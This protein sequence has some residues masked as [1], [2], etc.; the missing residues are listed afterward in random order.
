MDAVSA[1]SWPREPW[2]CSVLATVEDP[3][4]NG[5]SA[6]TEKARRTAAAGRR[7]LLLLASERSWEDL[8]AMGAGALL[9]IPPGGVPWGDAVGWPDVADTTASSGG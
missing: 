6:L 4:G 3:G 7:V 1:P 9:Y 8:R 2:S 5:L